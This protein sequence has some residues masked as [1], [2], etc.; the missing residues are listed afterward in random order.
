MT[1]NLPQADDLS[2]LARLR[3]LSHYGDLLF[4]LTWRDIRIKYKQSILGIGW[5]VLMPLVIVLA[6]VVVKAAFSIVSGSEMAREEIA[7]VSVR[8]V[9]FA[10]L[11]S[12]IRFATN[13]LVGNTNLVTKIY[14]PRVVLPISAVLSQFFDFV[15]AS[16]ILL[17]VLP[18]FGVSPRLSLLWIPP[19]VLLLIFYALGAGILLSAASLFFRDVKYIVEI[20]L[21]F[22][23]FFTPIFYDVSMFGDWGNL[24]LLNPVAPIFEAIAAAVFGTPMPSPLWLIY[25]AAIAVILLFGA[26]SLFSRLEKSF[27]EY[28]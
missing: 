16:T 17:F 7:N 22:A 13:C 28:I 9:P 26:M 6:G 2:G 5:A 1:L 18:F 27:A 12:S 20:I 14:F 24:L 8:S 11:I 15:I 25:S 19:L 23:I 4:M 21:T 10:F 3:Q